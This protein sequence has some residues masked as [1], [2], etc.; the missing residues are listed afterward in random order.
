[1]ASARDAARRADEDT[2]RDAEGESNKFTYDESPETG[3]PLTTHQWYDGSQRPWVFKR[4][5]HV[6]PSRTDPDTVYAGVEDAALFSSTDGGQNWKGAL[7]DY[8]ATAPVRSGS[9]EQADCACTRSSR[10]R[11]IRSD[12]SWRSRRPVHSGRTTVARR[13]S[14]STGDSR[15]SY[16]PDPKAEIGHCVHRIALHP[17]ATERVVHAEALGRPAQ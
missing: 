15:S 17:V 2:G 3:K 6:E 1:V 5:W 12:C 10:I 4:V 13:G 9:Q 16:I 8:A 11:R 14:R 7:G